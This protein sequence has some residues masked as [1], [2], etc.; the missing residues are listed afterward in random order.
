MTR[1]EGEGEGEGR[2]L[3]SLFSLFKDALSRF[4]TSWFRFRVHHPRQ[5]TPPISLAS[6]GGQGQGR[7]REGPWERLSSHPTDLLVWFL[8]FFSPFISFIQLRAAWFANEHGYELLVDS[9]EGWTYGSMLEVSGKTNKG[10]KGGKEGR[11][12]S[13]RFFCFSFSVDSCTF[14][15]PPPS[16]NDVRPRW[17]MANSRTNHRWRARVGERV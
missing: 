8:F 7:E 13:P 10:G 1:R 15:V 9:D 5:S 17:R 14:T 4:G 3:T 2:E 11:L 12:S 16:S 6:K